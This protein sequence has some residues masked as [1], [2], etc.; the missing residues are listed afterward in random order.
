[1]ANYLP[2][3][4]RDAGNSLVTSSNGAYVITGVNTNLGTVARSYPLRLIVHN[5]GTTAVLLQRAYYGLRQGTNLVVATQESLLD[6]A[7]LDTAR[8]VSAVHLP[9]TSTNGFWTFSGQLLPGGTLV[10]QTLLPYD[11]QASNP[12]LHTYHPDHDN[13]DSTFKTQL[14]P[15]AESY[16]VTR[17]ITLAITPPGNDFMSL[18]TAN[19]TLSGNYFETI[20][21]TGLGGFPRTF[22]VTGGFA[23]NRISPIAVLT[24]Q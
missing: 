13:L 9:W 19:Q 2:I 23:L 10:T 21:L 12:F 5:D 14:A 8:R 3:Y 20:T 15:G 18:T 17:Q 1:M 7:H 4:Q 22:N 11:D 24:T 6:P 16:E